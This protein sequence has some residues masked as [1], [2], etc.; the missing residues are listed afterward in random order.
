MSEQQHMGAVAQ[1]ERALCTDLDVG[2]HRCRKCNRVTEWK[3]ARGK[4]YQRCTECGSRFPCSKADCEHQDC[5]AARAAT[6]ER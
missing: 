5:E 1:L 3:W 6:A 2:Q 4:R